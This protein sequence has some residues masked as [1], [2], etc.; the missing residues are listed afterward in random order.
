MFFFAPGTFLLAG[1]ITG[2]QP[3]AYLRPDT[4]TQKRT[5]QMKLDATGDIMDADQQVGMA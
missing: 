2:A 5:M 4:T 3:K 1:L